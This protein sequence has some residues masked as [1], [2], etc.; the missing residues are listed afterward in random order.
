M[1]HATTR[2][3]SGNPHLN[4]VVKRTDEESDQSELIILIIHINRNFYGVIRGRH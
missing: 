4:A 1:E 2:G 3:T